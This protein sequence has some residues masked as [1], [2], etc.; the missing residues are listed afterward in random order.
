MQPAYA[1]PVSD[2]WTEDARLVATYDVECAGRHDHDFYLERIRS[3]G[4][5]A[6]VDLGCGTGVF[7]T[8]AHTLY[9]GI[10][11]VGVDPSPAMIDAARARDP[12]GKVT[13]LIGDSTAIP[14]D[15]VDLI[16]MMGHV[17]QY[18]V[19]DAEW[20]RTL[21]DC[22]RALRPGGHLTFEV[23]NPGAR[24]WECWTRSATFERFPHPDGGWFESWTE[25]V[26]VAGDP[27]APAETHEG[28]TVLPSGEHLVARETLRFR[29]LGEIT[30]A[31]DATGFVV[32]SLVG[33]WDG[34]P[35]LPTSPECI[36]LAHR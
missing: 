18:F 14:S 35:L 32:G 25:V 5:R 36:V 20:I 27:E 26:D 28:H 11:V 12:F 10:D 19:D 16:V 6:V 17:A 31:L 29:R 1:R 21:A 13:W 4:S 7:A 8:A 3:L 15:S 2:K 34:S 24:E 22:H 30:S 9:A 23:R 33:N